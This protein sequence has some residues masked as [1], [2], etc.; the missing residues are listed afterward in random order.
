VEFSL[1]VGKL[2]VGDIKSLAQ[3]SLALQSQIV[4]TFLTRKGNGKD[5]APV[6]NHETNGAVPAHITGVEAMPTKWGR[7]LYMTFQVNGEQVRLFGS[8]KRLGDALVLAGY[9]NVVRDLSE[10]LKVSLPCRV[11]TQPTQD[12]RYQNIERIFPP[13]Q[14]GERR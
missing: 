2:S 8:L 6:E 14:R 10:G 9:S 1:S 7:R 3:K 4:D 11:I 12:G 13:A 5:Q